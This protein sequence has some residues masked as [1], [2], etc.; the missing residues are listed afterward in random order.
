MALLGGG[1]LEGANTFFT[2]FFLEPMRWVCVRVC[3]VVWGCVGG[4]EIDRQLF[5]PFLSSVARSTRSGTFITLT[6]E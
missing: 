3:V 6:L 2:L 5:A 4:W 1:E